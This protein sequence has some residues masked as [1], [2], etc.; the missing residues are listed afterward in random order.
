[1]TQYL[2]DGH[3]VTN[4]CFYHA[5]VVHLSWDHPRSNTLY[6]DLSGSLSWDHPRSNTL[7]SDLSG[8]LSWDHPRSNTLYSDL[9]G[10]VMLLMNLGSSKVQYPV[11]QVSTKTL[12]ALP[13]LILMVEFILSNSSVFF[14][15]VELFWLYF[16]QSKA[17]LPYSV[18]RLIIN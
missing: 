17:C 1:M 6:S 18:S 9:S 13:N 16:D 12:T 11:L 7:Y 15:R 5:M 14:A 2:T 4:S 10:D 8:Y 3:Y